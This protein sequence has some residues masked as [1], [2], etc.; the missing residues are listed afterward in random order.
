MSSK[1]C[2]LS[3]QVLFYPKNIKYSSTKKL[4]P[5]CPKDK[6]IDIFLTNLHDLWSGYL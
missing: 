2:G 4:P 3:A 6:P 1:S 5:N